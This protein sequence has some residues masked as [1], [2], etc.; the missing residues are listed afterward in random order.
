MDLKFFVISLKHQVQ[1][2]AFMQE[3]LER[4][5]ID[6][7]FFDAVNGRELSDEDKAL[8]EFS[9]SAIL[10]CSGNHR[11]K[12]ECALS[13]GEIGCA[14]SHLKIYQQVATWLTDKSK[15]DTVAVV[16][17][18]NGFKVLDEAPYNNYLHRVDQSINR[19]LIVAVKA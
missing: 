10:T 9:D 17:E 15:T 6:F 18:E 4:F 1:K 7:E 12:I 13:P 2:R 5:G 14:L 11:V 19:N 3:Q 8:C 16:L